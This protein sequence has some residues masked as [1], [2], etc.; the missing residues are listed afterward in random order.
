MDVRNSLRCAIVAAAVFGFLCTGNANA[1][2]LYT[3]TDLGVRTPVALNNAG[4]VALTDSNTV[5][6]TNSYGQANYQPTQQATL[7]NSYGPQAGQI[8][9]VGQALPT[10]GNGIPCANGSENW[11]IGITSSGQVLV[12]TGD[13]AYLT[14][15]KTVVNVATGAGSSAWWVRGVNDN[16]QITGLTTDPGTGLMHAFVTDGTKTIDLGSLQGGSTFPQAINNQGQVVGESEMGQQAAFFDPHAFLYSNGKLIDLGT[17]PGDT[18]SVAF[19][20]NNLGQVVGGSGNHAFLYTN[21]TMTDLGLLPGS[22]STWASAINDKG[23]IVGTAEFDSPNGTST[24]HAVL[25][26]GGSV[27]DLNSLIDQNL[28]LQLTA[29]LAINSSGQILVAGNADDIYQSAYL[30]TPVGLPAP[31]PPTNLPEPA[32]WVVFTLAGVAIA[33]RR[34]GRAAGASA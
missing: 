14:D 1:D 15:G 6:T 5:V 3:V 18:T 30:L 19:G 12:G 2:P 33:A 17:L 27:L 21:G 9:Y 22:S 32:T 26:Q 31:T 13:G 28:H 20:I 23:Q 10:S 24:T 34:W 7:Y 16:G 25:L 4:Q 11:S 8:T 29:A